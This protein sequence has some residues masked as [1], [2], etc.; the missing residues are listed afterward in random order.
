MSINRQEK[1]YKIDLIKMYI[2]VSVSASQF[3][4]FKSNSILAILCF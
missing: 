3:G 4:S 2:N 1:S